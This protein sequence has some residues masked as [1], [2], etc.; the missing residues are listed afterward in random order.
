MGMGYRKGQTNKSILYSELQRRLRNTM[1]DEVLHDIEAVKDRS[2]PRTCASRPVRKWMKIIH[3]VDDF[4][5]LE[6]RHVF[7]A[8]L[9]FTR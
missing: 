1:T 2:G 4:H 9:P 8:Y 7:T 6:W 3:C 5:P